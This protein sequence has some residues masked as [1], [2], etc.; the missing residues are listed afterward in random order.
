MLFR[1]LSGLYPNLCNHELLDSAERAHTAADERQSIGPARS[2]EAP[3]KASAT[4]TSTPTL[5]DIEIDGKYAGSTKLSIKFTPGTHAVTIKRNGYEPWSRTIEV[6][7]GSELTINADL[8]PTKKEPAQ[9]TT[10]S[11]K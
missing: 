5:A 1:S 7:E 3:V 9:D 11:K 6:T 4:I 10:S 8:Q 2:T